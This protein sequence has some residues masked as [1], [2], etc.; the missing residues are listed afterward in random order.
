MKHGREKE[1]IKPQNAGRA[2][3][4]EGMTSYVRRPWGKDPCLNIV[5]IDACE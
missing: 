2:L 4:L 3:L 1:S 5:S